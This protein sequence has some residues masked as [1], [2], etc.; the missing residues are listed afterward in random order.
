MRLRGHYHEIMPD[1]DQAA[2]LAQNTLCIACEELGPKRNYDGL[3][4]T[5]TGY[6]V[7]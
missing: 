7:R 2:K 5:H 3:I 4:N 1:R 6:W